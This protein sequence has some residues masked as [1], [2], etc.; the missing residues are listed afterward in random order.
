MLGSVPSGGQTQTQKTKSI[1]CQTTSSG[2]V[3][4][5]K[6]SIA[7]FG[8]LL[9]L[10][11]AC[12]ANNARS[13]T[14]G[15]HPTP[16]SILACDNSA[17]YSLLITDAG[18]ATLNFPAPSNQGGFATPHFRIAPV[19]LE[20]TKPF[21]VPHNTNSDAHPVLWNCT[22]SGDN[23]DHPITADVYQTSSAVLSDVVL[24]S[25][26]TQQLTCSESK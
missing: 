23:I 7:A 12:G 14:E 24:G 8:T 20:C 13:V 5:M 16:V 10:L 25:S 17:G 3:L 18:K 9:L 19:S 1:D 26:N 15:F 4:N 2:K 11:T 6:T 22:Q 21:A